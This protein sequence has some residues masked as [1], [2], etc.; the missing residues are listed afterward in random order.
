MRFALAALPDLSAGVT[1]A[2]VAVVFFTFWRGSRQIHVLTFSLSF[3]GIAATVLLAGIDQVFGPIF[4]RGAVSD[5]A[6]LGAEISLLAGCTGLTG[7]PIPWRLLVSGG[8]LLYAIARITNLYGVPGALY[9]PELGAVA[10]G[11]IAAV[12]VTS[13]AMAGFRALASAFLVRMVVNLPWIW[14]YRRGL[15]PLLHSVDQILIVT[16]ALVLVVAELSRARRQAEVATRRE[17]RLQAEQIAAKEASR[18][19][20]EFLTNMSHELRTPLN[21][22]LGFAKILQRD[23]VMTERQIRGLKIID[24]SGQ[25]LLTLINDILDLASIESSKVELYPTEIKLPAF[26]QM[27]CDIIRVKA[28]EKN[29]LFVYQAAPDLPD[30]VRVDEKR[31]RQVLL[32]LLSNAV[33]FT[34]TGQVTLRAMR[35]QPPVAGAAGG[36]MVRLRFEVEDHGIG[37]NEAQLARLFRPFEQLA[38]VK[39]REG[40]T[41][42]GLAIS[43]ELVRL[44]GGDIEVRSRPGKGSVF[45]FDLEVSTADAQVQVP[46][47]RGAPIGYEGERRKILVVDDVP[48][49]LTMLLESLGTL[50]FEMA[51]ASNGE[52]ALEVAARF[53]PDLIAMD[54]MMPVMD[55]FEAMRRLRLMPEFAQV[56][57]IATSA[58]ATHEVQARCRAA[59]ANAFIP[60]PIEQDLL[61]ETMARLMDLTWICE[62]TTGQSTEIVRAGDRNLVCPPPEEMVVLRQLAR[63]GNMRTIVERADYLKDLDARYA[64]FATRLSTLAEHCQ[65]QAIVTLVEQYSAHQD[66]R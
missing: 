42:L 56:P 11:W 41:G 16:I 59:G 38:E 58:S 18:A 51:D 63:T 37:M 19:K 6:F 54:I 2:I 62:E 14:G 65:S 22:I 55:G 13:P 44:M 10:Y 34:D 40:G 45:W 31:L 49:N 57:F 21:G 30:A 33:K 27:V 35:L 8:F 36:A 12:F 3:A 9:L 48:H 52:E 29:L 25:H 61:L 64:P 66:E 39:R 4:W 1:D 47:A 53:R 15:A 17:L 60:K 46:P 24:E 26:L 32:N 20:S 28:E 23:K 7:R 5:A 50:G 43:R